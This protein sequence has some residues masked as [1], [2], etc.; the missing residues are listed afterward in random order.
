MARFPQQRG[1]VSA[2]AIGLAMATR[3]AAFRCVS[4][5]DVR[6]ADVTSSTASAAILH[7]VFLMPCSS[8]T[9]FIH[10]SAFR[11]VVSVQYGMA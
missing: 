6:L 2:L 8:H 7:G 10:G 4:E 11:I 9:T 5:Q 3:V 1:L